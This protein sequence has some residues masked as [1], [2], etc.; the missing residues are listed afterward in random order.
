MAR[1]G[2]RSTTSRPALVQRVD[3]LV[4]R[5]RGRRVLHLGCTNWPYTA[6][7]ERAGTLLHRQASFVLGGGVLFLVVVVAACSRTPNTMPT[8]V[9]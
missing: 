6:E 2:V 5:S 4:A 7:S 3:E 9:T 1:R 8:G